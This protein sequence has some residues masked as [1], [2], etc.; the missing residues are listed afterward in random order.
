[1]KTINRKTR[2]PPQHDQTWLATQ[3]G[4]SQGRVSQLVR[5]GRIPRRAAYD[6]ADVRTARRILADAR[7]AN[8]ATSAQVEADADDGNAAAIAAI[9][10]SPERVARIRLLIE[11]TAKIKLERELLA[12]A[13]LKKET[14]ENAGVAAVYV[15]RAKMQELPLRASLIAD[16][17]EA[18]A[19]QILQQWANEVVKFYADAAG[20]R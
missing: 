10:K 8:N 13:Y 7:A 9:T 11:R 18:E 20:I 14:V 1:V 12:G 19:A 6:D 5:D 4:L 15:V 17:P 2:K 3:L 16:K